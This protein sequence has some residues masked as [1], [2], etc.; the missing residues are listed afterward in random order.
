MADRKNNISKL[1]HCFGCGVCVKACPVKIIDLKENAN[2]F[3]Q[4]VIERQDRCIECG[5]C[6]KTCAFINRELPAEREG[7][8]SAAAW[9][10]DAATRREC[11]SGGIGYE[12]GK[13]LIE[14]GYKAVG[15]RYN[16]ATQ[17]AEHF[18]AST[19]D[20]FRA[21]MGSKYIPSTTTAALEQIDPAQRYFFTGT[22][23]QVASMRRFLRLR[24]KEENFV[25]MDFFCH[26][27]PSLLLWD[28]YLRK[29]EKTTGPVSYVSWRSKETGW[30]DSYRL[31]IKGKNGTYTSSLSQG[32]LFLR[33][34]LGNVFLNDCCYDCPFKKGKSAADIRIG[35]Q[36]GKTYEDN[37]LGVSS[38]ISFTAKG[39]E[40]VDSLGARATLEPLTFERAT[41]GQIDRSPE[42]PTMRPLI[43]AALRRTG[44][45]AAAHLLMQANRVIE[46]IKRTIKNR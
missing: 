2:G 36:W 33:Y 35:D 31:N 10:N 26:G 25:L 42:R 6:I 4:P 14:E 34:F 30:H 20:E 45:L 18:I 41:E 44:S 24:R 7:A 16:T 12:I 19:V 38:L 29:V 21:S 43:L 1:D 13:K 17:R 5:M 39:R 8:K 32:D 22:P 37:T 15:V 46:K 40:V 23:C 3:Y 27:V 9:S 28:S 11:S